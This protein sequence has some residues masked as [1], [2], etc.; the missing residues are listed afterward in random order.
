MAY[1]KGYGRCRGTNGNRFMLKPISMLLAALALASAAAPGDA[2]PKERAPDSALEARQQGRIMP[3]PQI[4][5]QVRQRMRGADYLG[6]ELDTSSG[7]YR[8]KFLRGER[9][10]WIDVDGR[11]GQEVGR[12][13]K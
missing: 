13:G 3:L 1:S 8:F 5:S 2:R 6:P 4:E 11:T 10:I 12:S 9:V 7:R